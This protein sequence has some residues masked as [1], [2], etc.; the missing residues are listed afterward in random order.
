MKGLVQFLRRHNLVFAALFF[1]VVGAAGFLTQGHHW[2]RD[3]TQNGRHTL[4]QASQELLGQMPGVVGVTAYATLQDPRHGDL[5]QPIRDFVARYQRLKPDLELSF[6]DP[7]REV[8]LARTA[9]VQVNG[10]LVL[11]YRGRKEHLVT[12]NEQ[13]FSNALMRLARGRERVVMS[14]AGHGERKLD[15]SAPHDLGEFGRQL[16]HKGFR[17]APLNLAVV[18][19]VPSDVNVLV[20]AQPRAE[21][22]AGEADRI[23]RYLAR[24][25]SLLWLLEPGPMHGLRPVA[26]ALNL[27]LTSGVVVDPAAREAGFPPATAVAAQ[28]GA[29]PVTARFDLVTVFP[30]VR[31]LGVNDDSAW[32]ATPLVEAAERGWVET[33]AADEKASLDAGQD[34]PGPVVTALALEREGEEGWQ[35]VAVVGGGGFLANAYLGNGGNLDLGIRLVNWLAGDARLIAI[36]PKNTIDA[37]LSLNRSGAMALALGFLIFLPLAFFVAAIFVW[38]R[39]NA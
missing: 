36:Q 15:G 2:H 39:R 10:E 4:S 1:S 8:E 16:M 23:R 25:G 32:R 17:V 24:G 27:N 33:G 22:L 21:I 26:E 38:R 30:N 37:A 20:L 18:D 6:V 19:E 35:R 13:D 7:S 34:I 11:V 3:V 14:L 29:H 9:E 31:A 12:L 5:R 28:Y